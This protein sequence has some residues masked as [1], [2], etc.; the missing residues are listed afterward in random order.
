MK[1]PWAR[2]KLCQR[3]EC[4]QLITGAVSQLPFFI[5]HSVQRRKLAC[6]TYNYSEVARGSVVVKALCYKPECRV[7]ENG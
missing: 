2:N 3:P 6:R 1:K 4:L 7:F 5:L